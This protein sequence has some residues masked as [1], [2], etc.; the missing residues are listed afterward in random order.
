MPPAI[1]KA[2]STW[3]PGP[4]PAGE[5]RFLDYTAGL[6]AQIERYPEALDALARF[7]YNPDQITEL[8]ALLQ[9][10]RDASAAQQK[11]KGEAQQATAGYRELLKQV[12]LA[13][14][15]LRVLAQQVLAGDP[16]LLEL[17]SFGA[18]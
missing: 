15:T 9:A 8:R 5:S 17:L 1:P 11:E 3:N 13:Y 18:A 12:Q 14:S 10:A 4:L 16:Q 6:L 2:P 7:G